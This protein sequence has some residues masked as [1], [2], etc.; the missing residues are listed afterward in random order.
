M[1]KLKLKHNSVNPGSTFS[2]QHSEEQFNWFPNTYGN[3]RGNYLIKVF[4]NFSCHLK[5]LCGHKISQVIL[6]FFLLSHL[7]TLKAYS[8]MFVFWK[9]T[10]TLLPRFNW[11]IQPKA[12]S[13]APGS[14]SSSFSKTAGT[15]FH[16]TLLVQKPRN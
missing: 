15:F 14:L 12:C 8:C 3:T 2:P 4:K 6:I 5:P 7:H 9:R 13:W 10:K 1:L 16:L 11:S